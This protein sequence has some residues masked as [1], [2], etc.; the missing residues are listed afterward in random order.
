MFYN[1]EKFIEAYRQASPQTQNFIDSNIISKYLQKKLAGKLTSVIIRD[2]VLH[3]SNTV[4]NLSESNDLESYIS[5]NNLNSSLITPVTELCFHF[6]LTE[7]D[8]TTLAPQISTELRTNQMNHD[9]H[10]AYFIHA[11]KCKIEV[12]EIYTTNNLFE[13]VSFKQFLIVI[14]DI[15]L[16]FYKIE[17]TA[18]LLQQELALDT[19]TAEKIAIDIQEFLKPLSD[20]NWQPPGDDEEE[21]FEASNPPLSNSTQS[22]LEP[23]T[24]VHFEQQ[25]AIPEIRTMASDMAQERSP[26]RTTFN[27]VA[28]IDE[29]IYV[30]TQPTLERTAVGVPT[31]TQ[32]V[33]AKPDTDES[34]WS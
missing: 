33:P 20:P 3:I 29:P 27:A 9:P 11:P 16:G 8:Y 5:K 13:V 12:A 6:F 30:S 2:L 21:E 10:K 17:D 7:N 24:P 31:Y 34:R 18:A 22:P 1:W 32:P 19:T 15:A 4:L 23:S 14:G 28:N 25:S 26:A